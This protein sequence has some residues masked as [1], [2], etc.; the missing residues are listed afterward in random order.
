[1]RRKSTKLIAM[2]N[3]E[4]EAVSGGLPVV[5][6]PFIYAGVAAGAVA[7]WEGIKWGYRA[8]RDDMRGV[9]RY[10]V[11]V[12]HGDQGGTPLQCRDRN[13]PRVIASCPQ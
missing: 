13:Q 4:L 8:L 5:A 2:S 1:M 12:P 10:T 7:A 6:A 11:E 3:S 9:N